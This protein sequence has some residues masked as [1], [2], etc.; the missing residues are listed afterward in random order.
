MKLIRYIRQHRKE[1]R[2]TFTILTTNKKMIIYPTM[3]SREERKQFEKEHGKIG[4]LRIDFEI[5]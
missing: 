1:G 4:A 5:D 2:A 3:F